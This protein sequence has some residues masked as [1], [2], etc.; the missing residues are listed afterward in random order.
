MQIQKTPRVLFLYDFPLSG[1]GSGAYI[2][3]LSL[4][5]YEKYKYN[6]AIAA[7]DK[8][9]IHEHIPFYTIKL[10]QIPVYIGR[11]GLESSKKYKDLTP[12]E[13][14]DLYY[15]FIKETIKIIKDF[16]PD[17]INAH[18]IMINAWAA[19]YIRSLF[20]IKFIATSHGSCLYTIYQDKRYFRMTRDTLRAASAITVV[21][22]DTR[23]KLLKL[24]NDGLFK[25]TRTIPGG[26]ALSH[27][28]KKI[29]YKDLESLAKKYNIQKER[30]VLFS[31][32]LI[33][34]KGVDY[35]IKAA[36]KINGQVVIVGDGPQKE[37]LKNL[38]EEYKLTNVN[39]LGYINHETLMKI[40]YLAD[41]FVSPSVWDDPMPLTVVE[42]MAAGLPLVVTRRGGIPLAVKDSYNGFFVRPR[43]AKDIVEKVNRLLENK[44]LCTKMGERGRLVVEKKFTWTK[45]AERFHRLFISVYRS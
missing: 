14:T 31:G 36:D 30:V 10:P 2:K 6:I 27:F 13:I 40:Y 28:P 35:L 37:N 43:S 20:G 9:K 44:Q 32:R 16:K 45:I 8:Q 17:I 3:Y 11:P 39:L 5:L 22:G 4:K 7:P 21:S 12:E 33:S 15:A 25:K 1:G 26:V 23:A 18:H 29:E 24:F 42:A 19:R 41:V 38:I 34:E